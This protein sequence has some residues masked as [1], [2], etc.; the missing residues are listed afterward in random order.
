MYE[1]LHEELLP[2]PL[3]V[4]RV[5]SHTS[6]ALAVTAG[7]LF[8]GMAGYHFLGALGWVDSFL[9]ASMI[10]GGMGPVNALDTT[11]AKLFAG[12]YALFAGLVFVGVCGLILA[13]FLHRL[14]H[15]FHLEDD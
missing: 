12:S 9:N 2:R 3:F 8:A 7:T 1:K 5:L 13:P 15:H 11:A 14:L 4:K 6:L 10:L